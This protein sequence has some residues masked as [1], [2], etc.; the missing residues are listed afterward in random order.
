MTDYKQGQDCSERKK[1]LPLGKGLSNPQ[2]LLPR[3]PLM[4]GKPRPQNSATNYVRT[5]KLILGL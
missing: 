4:R 1:L 2:N 3:I 5:L